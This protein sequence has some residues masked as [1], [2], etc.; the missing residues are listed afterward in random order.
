[1]NIPGGFKEEEIKF[2]VKD[3]KVTVN[4]NSLEHKKKFVGSFD[5]EGEEYDFNSEKKKIEIQGERVKVLFY[6]W[7]FQ[8]QQIL[9]F[10]TQN[11]QFNKNMLQI[12][13]F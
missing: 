12:L 13:S 3:Q 1:M 4:C 2:S 5:L 9:T 10:K 6:K 8:I 7:W 11:S